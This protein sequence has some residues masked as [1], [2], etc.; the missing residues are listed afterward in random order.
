MRDHPTIGFRDRFALPL[1]VRT[2]PPGAQ[3]LVGDSGDVAGHSPTTIEY[4][5]EGETRILIRAPGYEDTEV[6]RRGAR[7]DTSSIVDVVL[8]KKV[9]WTV[10]A[11]APIQSRA[12]VDSTYAYIAARDGVVRSYARSDGTHVGGFES[13]LLGGFSSAPAVFGGRVFVASVEGIGFI[14][15]SG[16][17]KEAGRFCVGNGVRLDLLAIPHGVLVADQSGT[18]SL[19]DEHGT[20]VWSKS[21][22][23]LAGEPVYCTLGIVLLTTSGEIEILNAQNGSVLRRIPLAGSPACDAPVVHGTTLYT[24]THRRAIVAVDLAGGR[25]LWRRD[26]HAQMGGR[27]AATPNAVAWIGASGEIHVFDRATGDPRSVLPVEG[28]AA[29]RL[30]SLD[31]DILCVTK[32]GVVRRIRDDGTLVWLLDCKTPLV[33]APAFA[34]G[35]VVVTGKSGLVLEIAP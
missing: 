10:D 22:G 11:G 7:K 5:P 35:G 12:A 26:V 19:I 28:E 31:G 33:P 2:A 30:A 6:I 32:S 3:I 17:L 20:T 29:G 27:P 4:P 14:F 21:V 34:H 18:L 13:D 9:R 25:E 15:Q 23:V 1:T 24:A 8:S 16:T